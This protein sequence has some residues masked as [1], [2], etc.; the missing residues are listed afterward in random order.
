ME[1]LQ[2]GAVM[3]KL[4]RYSHMVKLYNRSDIKCNI[5]KI[6]AIVQY[7]KTLKL[8]FTHLAMNTGHLI[9][10]SNPLK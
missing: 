6:K 8:I 4:F 1:Q 2:E 7:I 3:K 10:K 5:S 9:G